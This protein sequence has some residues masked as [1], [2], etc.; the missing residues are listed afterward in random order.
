MSPG[1]GTAA[2]AL[3]CLALLAGGCSKEAAGLPSGAAGGDAPRGGFL[4]YEHDVRIDLEPDGL[5][6]RLAGAQA[7]CQQATFGA[8]DVLEVGHEGGDWPSA[9]LVVRIVPAGV[10][11]MIAAASR[12]AAIGSRSTHAEDLARAVQDNERLQQRLRGE[13][14]RLL[15]FQQRR[16]LAVADMIA[17]SR[18]LAEVDAQL[19][20]AAQESAQQQRRLDTQKL[21]LRFQPAGGR[22]GRGEIVQAMRDFTATLA[23]GTAWTIRAVAFL[24]PVAL[25]A[26]V[27]L[28]LWRRLRRRRS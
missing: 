13:Q 10:E 27:L 11:P 20:A 9:R 24:I 6:A 3:A 1:S 26:G 7:A 4:A 2:A 18:Q 15:E 28:A 19:Q 5:A 22:G 23:T 25:A 14:A 12:G 8:C 21:T 17:L 16:D